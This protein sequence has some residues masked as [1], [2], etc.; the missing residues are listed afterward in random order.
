MLW[1]CARTWL[2]HATA[3]SSAGTALW[4][5]APSQGSR[6]LCRKRRRRTR[7]RC[8]C[9]ALSYLDCPFLHFP[10]SLTGESLPLQ[11]IA[12]PNQ[13]EVC[14]LPCFVLTG[15]SLLSLFVSSD[16]SLFEQGKLCFSATPL[17][18]LAAWR[19]CLTGPTSSLVSAVW[20]THLVQCQHLLY[21]TTQYF[22]KLGVSKQHTLFAGSRVVSVEL[23]KGESKA[24]MFVRETGAYTEK[25]SAS[26]LRF[27][28]QRPP[29]PS[30]LQMSS[31]P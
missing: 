9:L 17:C 26:V 18:S 22:D 4:M 29:I 19:V 27:T 5:R 16:F 30:V 15:L 6:F 24:R 11:K 8:V 14:P 2:P 25:V 12:A 1:R 21:R 3:C 23:E 28:K 31:P 7:P 20:V 10:H 13:T